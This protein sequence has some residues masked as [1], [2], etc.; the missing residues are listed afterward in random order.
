[1][2]QH[3]IIEKLNEAIKDLESSVAQG[4]LNDFESYKYYTGRIQGF[5]DSINIIH[6]L[7]KRTYAE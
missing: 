4:Q 5:K 6:E 1:M 7:I 3:Q 2:I